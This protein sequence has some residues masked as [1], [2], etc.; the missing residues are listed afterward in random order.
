V[1]IHDS[2][3]EA[4][5]EEDRLEAAA[6][7]AEAAALWAAGWATE[8]GA[9]LADVVG[10]DAVSDS[11]QRG[12]YGGAAAAARGVAAIQAR[13]LAATEPYLGA[14]KETAADA[15]EAAQAHADALAASAGQIWGRLWGGA[16][17]EAAEAGRALFCSATETAVPRSTG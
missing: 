4:E 5:A 11:V 13:G 14:A 3:A 17:T 12:I 10:L 9:A 16:E 15:A 8:K 1:D 7:R 6:R 2:D